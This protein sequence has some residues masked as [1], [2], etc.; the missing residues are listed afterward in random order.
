M[1][2][3]RLMEA[4]GAIR[5]AYVLEA[6]PADRYAKPRST[7]WI[8][9]ILVFLLGT[10]FFTQTA[11]GAAAA[12]FVGA[13]VSGWFEA[14]FPPKEVTATVEGSPEQETYIAGGQVPRQ[15]D[16][17]VSPGFAIYYDSGAYEMTEES[18]AT[19]IR[20][21]P[22]LPTREE[23]RS[24]HAALL[25][26][27]SPEDVEKA[28]DALLAQQEALYAALPECELEIRHVPDTS[29]DTLAATVR[30]EMQSDWET[31]SAL[32]LY[33]PLGCTMFRASA[34]REWDSPV[35]RWYFADDGQ[36]GTYQITVR[37]FVEAEEGH[38]ARL[39]AILNTFEIISPSA[40]PA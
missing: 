8:A 29:P 20:S 16:A 1:K 7:R 25:E 40:P 18:G 2:E 19:Y 12:A 17:A 36:T 26:G 37:Y 21:L 24:S 4:L 13:Q 30:Q 6:A 35:E 23:I 3:E 27:L 22:V 34:G 5:D 9:A 33:T 39:T 11:P 31:V 10:A 32:E 28:I 38:G 14:L 15:E